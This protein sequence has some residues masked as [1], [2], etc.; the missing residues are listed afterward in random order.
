MTKNKEIGISGKSG[1]SRR[2]FTG[3]AVAGAAALPIVHPLRLV[4]AQAPVRVGVLL[5]RSGFL[6][7]IGSACWRGAE[8]APGILS[9]MGLAVEVVGADT[10]SNPDTGRTQAERL[11][12]DGV[13]MLVGCFD[14]GTT[15]AVAQVAEQNGT[16]FV[17]NIAADPAITEQGYQYVFRNFPKAPA[18]VANGL[19]SI[20]NLF[21]VT[22]TTPQT[23][24]FMH[25]NDTFGT[26]MSR[27]IQ[28]LAPVVG[29]PYEIL[30]SI[31]Y[32][33]QARD[34][35]VEVARARAL[36]PDFL[37]V[38]T[39]LNDAILLVRECV[40][41]RFETMGIISPGSPGMYEKQFA[42][43]LGPYAEY[44][45]TSVPWFNP[46]SPVTTELRDRFVAEFPDQTFELNPGFTFE[47]L[48]IC[49]DAAQR[50]GSTN[51][52]D[53][54]AAL[55]A[56]GI[57]EHPMY[58]GPIVFDEEGQNPNIGTVVVQIQG[59]EPVVTAPVDIATSDPVFPVPGWNDRG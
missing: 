46:T 55:R 58:G 19:G 32:D 52:D 57:A 1:I 9:D 30:D 36:Q 29:V 35:S 37:M 44:S 33:P 31:S 17:I 2:K 14:S 28:A 8:L 53:L 34:L 7:A 27:G 42:D 50:A 16:P 25:I 18:L 11:I 6:S 51:A 41:Q 10:E 49:A 56:T 54:V 22:G 26:A 45:T 43:T 12:R 5:P 13:D 38:V 39:R 23:T 4:R 40:R 3:A 15:A 21:D 59:G 48:M 24:V 47:A 20:N